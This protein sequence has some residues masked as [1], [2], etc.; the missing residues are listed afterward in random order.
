MHKPQVQQRGI[1][2]R[3]IHHC[4]VLLHYHRLIDLQSE[5]IPRAPTHWRGGGNPIIQCVGS[6][7]QEQEQEQAQ[8]QVLHWSG[9]YVQEAAWEKNVR[10]RE[11]AQNENGVNSKMHVCV[12]DCAM[13]RLVEAETV[14]VLEKW[15][16]KSI[17]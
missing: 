6:R 9:N 17:N 2:P 14:V 15:W 3:S 11:N 7:Q 16:R 10:E 13:V 12:I 1:S 4:T 8:P 5:L